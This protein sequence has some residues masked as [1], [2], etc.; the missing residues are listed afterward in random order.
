VLFSLKQI[1]GINE[2]E[3]CVSCL[4]AK[5]AEHVISLDYK[6]YLLTRF[7]DWTTNTQTN[8]CLTFKDLLNLLYD[9]QQAALV[10]GVSH[11]YLGYIYIY[12]YIHTYIHTHTTKDRTG[13]LFSFV[14]HSFRF[15]ILQKGRSI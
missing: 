15:I 5:Q 12:T 2:S 8:V 14:R 11:N 9:T 3:L 13:A 1:R 4:T 10:V 6:C 7:S